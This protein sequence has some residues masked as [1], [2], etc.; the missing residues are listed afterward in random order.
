MSQLVYSV[1]LTKRNNE[2]VL[3]V[4]DALVLQ[5]VQCSMVLSSSTMSKSIT[6]KIFVE[7]H[8][9]NKAKEVIA[10]LEAT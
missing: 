9:Y 8:N 1:V 6:A 4:R 3:K 10:A 5:N 7:L 2:Q